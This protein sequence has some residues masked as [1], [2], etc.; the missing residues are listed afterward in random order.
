MTWREREEGV[1]GFPQPTFYSIHLTEG[2]KLLHAPYKP[3]TKEIPEEGRPSDTLPSA[4]RDDR[5]GSASLWET[6][7]TDPTILVPTSVMRTI[8]SSIPEEH[9]HLGRCALMVEALWQ[10]D[11]ISHT[12]G[13]CANSELQTKMWMCGVYYYS[14]C[15]NGN[16]FC[17]QDICNYW[18]LLSKAGMYCSELSQSS[19]KL[20]SFS[21]PV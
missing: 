20:C 5:R 11:T 18:L 16:A 19:Y 21:L 6:V 14:F 13:V 7:R 2:I 10:S 9:I 15:H 17:K 8:S 3:T 12:S 4:R 1:R